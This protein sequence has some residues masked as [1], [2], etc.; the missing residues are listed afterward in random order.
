M[1]DLDL[2]KQAEQGR[3]PRA[4]PADPRDPGQSPAITR[5]IER[6]LEALGTNGRETSSPF[7]VGRDI[8]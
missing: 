4:R 7:A 1:P 8:V 2:I 3:H 5:F 6:G